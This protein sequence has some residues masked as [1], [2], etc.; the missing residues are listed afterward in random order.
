VARTL[1]NFPNN[2]GRGELI[3]LRCLIAH[4][5][6][7]GYRRGDLGRLLPQ[8]LI[9]RFE[10]HYAGRLVFSAELFAAISANPLIAFDLRA[11]ES[12]PLR[13]SWHGDDGFSHSEEL[14]LTVR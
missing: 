2:V 14:M 1:I 3:E 11:V 13:F 9:R 7:T 6:E 5:M 4:P 12:A 10:C 8:N